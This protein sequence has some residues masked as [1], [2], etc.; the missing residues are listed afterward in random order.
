MNHQKL[1]TVSIMAAILRGSGIYNLHLPDDKIE[2]AA[3]DAL[4][5][6]ERVQMKM[7]AL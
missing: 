3:A 1:Q 4:T 6:Y 5:I 7:G 2:K